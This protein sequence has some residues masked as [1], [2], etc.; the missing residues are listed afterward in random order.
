MN[1]ANKFK[2]DACTT[3]KQR[4]KKIMMT[5]FARRTH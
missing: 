4:H 5:Y 3:F 1:D 2:S